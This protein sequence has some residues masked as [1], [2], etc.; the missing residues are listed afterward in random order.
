MGHRNQLFTIS[1][2]SP[3]A[4]GT[5]ALG[6]VTGLQAYDWFQCFAILIGGTSTAGDVAW[7]QYR[8]DPDVDIWVDWVRFPAIAAGT[9]YKY[10]FQPFGSNSITATGSG[11]LATPGTV[12][13][14]AN[15]NCGG[16]PGD[17][18]RL[19]FT[20]GASTSAG[21]AQKVYLRGWK[22]PK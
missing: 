13:L 8:L 12:G 18:V 19:V 14:S 9:T 16:H 10:S 11:V 21:A 5:A 6:T 1:A 17:T 22:A 4:A 15:T 7:L 20:A 3:A 2:T